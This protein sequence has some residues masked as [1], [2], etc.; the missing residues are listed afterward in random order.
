MLFLKSLFTFFNDNKK[1]EFFSA[2]LFF[3]IFFAFLYNT[4][5]FSIF[6]KIFNIAIIKHNSGANHYKKS[7]QTMKP[8]LVDHHTLKVSKTHNI[9]RRITNTRKPNIE[10]NQWF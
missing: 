9:A 4:G 7:I 2:S 1:Q 10:A 6:K 5:L 8:A 3:R